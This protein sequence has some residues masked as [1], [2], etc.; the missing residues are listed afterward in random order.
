MIEDLSSDGTLLRSVVVVASA[1]TKGQHAEFQR[2]N[3]NWILENFLKLS[4]MKITPVWNA[5]ND[6]GVRVL[7][8][9]RLDSTLIKKNRQ[10]VPFKLRSH[11]S[12]GPIQDLFTPAGVRNFGSPFKM[13][14]LIAEADGDF[15]G[16]IKSSPPA[17]LQSVT[18]HQQRRQSHSHS[19]TTSFDI[20]RYRSWREERRA[21]LRS[22]PRKAM[23]L[24]VPF[25]RQMLFPGDCSPAQKKFASPS[26]SSK[27]SS[28]KWRKTPPAP[29]DK[30]LPFRTTT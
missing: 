20:H 12:L 14:L 9:P 13:Y 25:R 7:L 17:E 21:R 23:P 18:S 16:D 26:T 4:P 5:F 27:D 15:P 6:G 8:S 19:P 22:K 1:R 24:L 11:M 29:Q 28:G 3:S 2:P 10:C 30:A